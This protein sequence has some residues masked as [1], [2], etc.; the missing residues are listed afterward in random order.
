[1]DPFTAAADETV[2][3]RGAIAAAAAP[4][5]PPTQRL[6]GL[7]NGENGWQFVNGRSRRRDVRGGVRAAGA[8]EGLGRTVRLTPAVSGNIG[9]ATSLNIGSAMRK[10]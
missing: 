9:T 10:Q 5:H 7:V 6:A 2:G 1:M 8:P 4:P 3:N